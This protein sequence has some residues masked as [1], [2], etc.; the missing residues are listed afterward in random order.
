MDNL[1]VKRLLEQTCKSL[2]MDVLALGKVYPTRL[3]DK[4]ALQSLV[5]RLFPIS[6]GR[7][8]IRLGPDGDGGYLVPDDLLGI[9]ACFSPG[10]GDIFGFEKDCAALGMKVFLA[11]GSVELPAELHDQFCF[12]K[13]HVGVTTGDDYMTVDDWVASS[14]LRLQSD[15]MLQIDIESN[16][17]E[18]FLGMSDRLMRRF[19]II[20]AEFHGLDQLWNRPFF[21]LASRAFEKILQ[22]HTCV[23]IHPNNCC[24]ALDKWGLT[25]PRLAEFTFLRNDRIDKPSYADVFPHPLDSDNKADSPHFPLPRCWYSERST[26]CT[27][28]DLG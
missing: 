13:K 25:I 14:P 19:R 27:P 24:G 26:P 5:H 7:Q 18:T 15:L 17:Y 3:T 22:T 20:V 21:Q 1:P 2:A 12:T 28:Y 6:P 8:L 4:S 23:H 9:E 16:E 10:V 11:D